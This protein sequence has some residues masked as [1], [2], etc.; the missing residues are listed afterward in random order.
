MKKIVLTLSVVSA[1]A[2]VQ[3]MAQ[4]AIE[5]AD[6][7]GTYSMDEMKVAYPDLT[8]EVFGQA[9]A[10][11]DGALDADELAAAREAGLIPA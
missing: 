8:E 5:D 7:N 9:D 6:G 4:T 1:L 11:A 2:A 10:N 3:A